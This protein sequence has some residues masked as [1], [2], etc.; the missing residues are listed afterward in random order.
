MI[1]ILKLQKAVLVII[2]G[3]IGLIIYKI[4]E[5]NKVES[6]IYVLKISG[7]LFLVGA[8]WFLYPIFFAKKVNDKE[9]QLDPEKHDD[10]E[11]AVSSRQP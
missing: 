3:V 5:A 10:A 7:G 8:L 2:L 1:K 9:V 4:M 6:G 11:G